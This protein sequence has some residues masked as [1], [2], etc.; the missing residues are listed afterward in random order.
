MT[1]QIHYRITWRSHTAFP[2]AHASTQSGAGQEFSHHVGL[3]DAPDPRRLDLHA[4]LKDPFGNWLVRRFR[5]RS[6]IAVYVLADLSASMGFVGRHR[7]LDVLADL[8]QA[9]AYATQRAGDRFGFIGGDALR[10]EWFV[11]AGHQ[12]GAGIALG[13]RL[14][15]FTPHGSN[16]DAG[17][18]ALIESAAHLAHRRALVFVVSD[19]HFPLEQLDTLL[20]SLTGH[21]VVPVVIWDRAE[22]ADL[23]RWGLARLRDS[24][25]KRTRLV[26]LTPRFVSDLARVFAVRKAQLERCFMQHNTAP[27]ILLDGFRADAV[28][29]YFHGGAAQSN[30]SAGDATDEAPL[31]ALA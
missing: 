6:G 24:E 2:G 18:D 19:F 4:S 9:L 27:L 11:P 10:G 31:A 5:Q 30:A 8:V 29:A 3:L 20:A 7:K 12:A 22:F 17:G 21:Q 1:A 14:R 16:T 28:S 26:L 15:A 25:S 23:P 13:E